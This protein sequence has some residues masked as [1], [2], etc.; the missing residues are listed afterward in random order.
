MALADI[1]SSNDNHAFTQFIETHEIEDTDFVY[2]LGRAAFYGNTFVVETLIA[3][4]P[5]QI[6]ARDICGETAL[7]HAACGGHLEIVKTLLNAGSQASALESFVE[8]TPT[9][10]AICSGSL[11]ILK[12][13]DAMDQSET[14]E[15]R[16]I[17]DASVCQN[18]NVL[19]FVAMYQPN[20][21]LRSRIPLNRPAYQDL[22]K[23]VE[24]VL[25]LKS[26]LTS[27]EPPKLNNDDNEL[28]YICKAPIHCMLITS[29]EYTGE[30]SFKEEEILE[31]RYR[32]YFSRSFV[33]TLLFWNE[34]L[35][36]Q[37]RPTRKH[38]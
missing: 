7:H 2:S 12:L 26:I 29:G 28:V 19:E 32:I 27:E 20:D 23:N 21:L 1:V 13:L 33:H 15:W 37:R 11:E 9:S 4:R 30:F 17:Y 10:R 31:A 36:I 25:W 38:E 22:V 8:T 35:S 5:N 24:V 34:L 14:N 16:Y 6:D 3:L 18:S